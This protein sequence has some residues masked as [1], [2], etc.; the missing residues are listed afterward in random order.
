MKTTLAIIIV[1]AAM[2]IVGPAIAAH[3]SLHH[4]HAEHARLQG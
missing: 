1:I 4:H 2:G 3:K